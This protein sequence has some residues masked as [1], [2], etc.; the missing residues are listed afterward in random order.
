MPS[1]FAARVAVLLMT[2]PTPETSRAQGWVKLFL[3]VS[4]AS[5]GVGLHDTGAGLAVAGVIILLSLEPLL[6]WLK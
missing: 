2:E 5:I 4:L 1:R 3:G 6:G